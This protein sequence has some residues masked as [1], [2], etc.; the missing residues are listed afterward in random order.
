MS[1]RQ[2]QVC[3]VTTSPRQLRISVLLSVHSSALSLVVL[4]YCREISYSQAQKALLRFSS[5]VFPFGH[6]KE[7]NSYEVKSVSAAQ[8]TCSIQAQHAWGHGIPLQEGMY[9]PFVLYFTRVMLFHSRSFLVAA[10]IVVEGQG[11][12]ATKMK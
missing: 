5:R 6:A 3:H 1:P 11:S 2:L 8:S 9:T 10:A 7:G 12:K 4:G